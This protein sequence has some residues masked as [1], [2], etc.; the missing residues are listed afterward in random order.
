VQIVEGV[1][2]A[3]ALLSILFFLIYV[4]GLLR[5]PTGHRPAVP[6]FNR[7]GEPMTPKPNPG[8]EETADEHDH[9]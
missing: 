5:S 2:A 9:P 7:F 1:I 8:Y 3:T 6:T 4:I